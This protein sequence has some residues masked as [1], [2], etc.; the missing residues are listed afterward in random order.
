METNAKENYLEILI[1]RLKKLKK[2]DTT[3]SFNKK[4]F[5]SRTPKLVI[6]WLNKSKYIK[7]T[8]ASIAKPGPEMSKEAQHL[9]LLYLSAK[10]DIESH[11]WPSCLRSRK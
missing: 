2:L 3:G 5:L 1:E 7:S 8:K 9:Y 4:L 6:K 11:S 10:V